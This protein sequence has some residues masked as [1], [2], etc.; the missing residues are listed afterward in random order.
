M[1]HSQT[2]LF[3]RALNRRM[4]VRLVSAAGAGALMFPRLTRAGP[5]ISPPQ[6]QLVGFPE[7]T[8]L[9]L[10]T[11]RP[12]QLETPL[13]YFRE[14]LTPNEAFYVRWH[15]EGIPTSV[16]LRSFRLQIRGEVQTPLSL[17]LA[18]LR[19]LEPISIIAVN[20]CSGNSRS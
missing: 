17:T 20:Q 13:H 4:F 14:D 3:S 7:K 9:I 18:D 16:N 11:D 8:D 6:E 5:N 15:L 1:Q 12:P 2:Q 10:R 19:K